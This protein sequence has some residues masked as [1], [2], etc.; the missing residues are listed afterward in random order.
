MNNK[1]LHQIWF[2]FGGGVDPPKKYHSYMNSWKIY[3]PDRKY[4]LWNEQMG[5]SFMKK[6]YSHY[7]D[8]YQ[9]LQYPVMKVDF[10][11][12]CL[13][14]IYGGIYA[15]IDYLCLRNFDE[16]IDITKIYFNQV[17]TS[18][19]HPFSSK[20]ELCNSLIISESKDRFW[21]LF[22]NELTENIRQN[23]I[24]TFKNFNIS[25]VSSTT[26][27]LFVSRFIWKHKDKFSNIVEALPQDQFNYFNGTRK[28]A[29]LNKPLYSRHDYACSWGKG[30]IYPICKLIESLTLFEFFVVLLIFFLFIYLIVLKFFN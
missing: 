18:L 16:Y 29:S 25:Y 9:Q 23:Q 24:N 2:D 6:H 13:L 28:F 7:Y 3:H 12:Y 26:G 14:S 19:I 30:K 17:A 10:L 21:N 15:D 1:Y 8:L 4:I 11:R 27:P 20:Y 5:N 22:I